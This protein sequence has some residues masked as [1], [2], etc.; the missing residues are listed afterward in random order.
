MGKAN[1]DRPRQCLLTG[2]L[3]WGV[4]LADVGNYSV[5]PLGLLW[6]NN[7]LR[8][9]RNALGVTSRLYFGPASQPIWVKEETNRRPAMRGIDPGF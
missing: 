6:P 5:T 1:N 3:P 8:H 2:N 7:G 9:L 4:L